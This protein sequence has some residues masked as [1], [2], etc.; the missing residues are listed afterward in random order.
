VRLNRQRPR[1]WEQLAV[2]SRFASVNLL[3][4]MRGID[5]LRNDLTA[6]SEA[7]SGIWK[8][9]RIASIAHDPLL[10]HGRSAIELYNA[11][12]AAASVAVA[13]GYEIEQDEELEAQIDDSDAL[14]EA[15][16]V[17]LEPELV[18]AFRGGV[19]ALER[20]GTD[21]QRHTMVSFREVA[22]HVLHLL[23]PDKQ[24]IGIAQPGDLVNGRPT[25]LFRLRYIFGGIA[26]GSLVD[27]Y[28][29][30]MRSAIQLFDLLNGDT[31]RLGNMAT[32]K[33][34]RYLKS[35]LTGLLLSLLEAREF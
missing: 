4:D 15:R 13:S 6:L 2:E 31:H 5:L 28:N 33:Q 25:R 3:D 10:W 26:N 34:A 12:Q 32:A 8:D 20:G 23:A 29:A 7:A 9:C 30:D 14:L 19:E 18:T 1:F 16:L 11:A 27:F 21:W 17:R 24:L 22:T 35:R